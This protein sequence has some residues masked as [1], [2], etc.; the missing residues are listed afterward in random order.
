MAG[1]TWIVKAYPLI[2]EN[3]LSW[4]LLFT[5][6]LDV[7]KSPTIDVIEPDG[8]VRNQIVQSKDGGF[9][10][11]L[12]V[13]DTHQTLASSFLVENFSV[14]VQHIALETKGIFETMQAWRENS[15]ANSDI[16]TNKY[17]DFVVC[18][19][20]PDQLLEKMNFSTYFTVK[21]PGELLSI[22]FAGHRRLFLFRNYPEIFWH[23]GFGAPI[24]SFRIAA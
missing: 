2:F 5:T 14:S 3:M 22:L 6:L 1:P 8:I 17:A 19:G 16:S 13:A 20:L 7:E 21:T 23:S 11:T 24:A 18:F 15:F 12:N 10:I 4:T 9:K